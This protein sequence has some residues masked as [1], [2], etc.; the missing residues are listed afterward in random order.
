MVLPHHSQ[1]SESDEKKP[2]II[3]ATKKDDV[4]TELVRKLASKTIAVPGSP[5]KGK[6]VTAKQ[7]GVASSLTDIS[8]EEP[9]KSGL[10]PTKKLN[11]FMEHS[12]SSPSVNNYGNTYTGMALENKQSATV[13]T[14]TAPVAEELCPGNIFS[15]YTSHKATSVAEELCPGNIFSLY[16]S[17]KTTS[18]AEELCPGR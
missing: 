15:L 6:K 1:I 13:Y 2:D 4:D 17:H 16:T 9:P 10:K 8:M 5:E 3:D 7:N 14:L 12:Q 18:V 11:N